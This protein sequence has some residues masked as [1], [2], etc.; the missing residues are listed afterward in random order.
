MLKGDVCYV[1]YCD[2]VVP[3]VLSICIQSGISSMY[4]HY[5]YV[6]L[7]EGL[8]SVSIYP[9]K[10]EAKDALEDYL[11]AEERYEGSR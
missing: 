9:T 4:D 8:R 7:D 6:Y 11:T 1:R 5:G 2:T 10:E 3:G